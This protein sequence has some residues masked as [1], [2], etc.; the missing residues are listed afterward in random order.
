MIT[1]KV[2]NGNVDIQNDE[3][4]R[5]VAKVFSSLKVREHYGDKIEVEAHHTLISSF[6]TLLEAML[7]IDQAQSREDKLMLIKVISQM[8]RHQEQLDLASGQI[9]LKGI[10]VAGE[11]LGRKSQSAFETKQD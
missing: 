5:I 11:R 6:K 8:K 4:Q 2:P 3:V 9:T 10:K 7:Q 1:P